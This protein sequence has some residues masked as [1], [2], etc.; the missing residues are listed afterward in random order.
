ML[1]PRKRITKREIKEDPLVTYYFKVRKFFQTYSKQVN[2]GLTVVAGLVIISVLMV[3]SK[4]NAEFAAAG[5]LGVA[6]NYYFSNMYERSIDELT[7]IIQTYSGTKAAG[8]ATFYLAN[9]YFVLHDFENAKKYYEIYR[10]K[11]NDKSSFTSSSLAGIAA[12]LESQEKFLE[13]AQYYEQ[14]AKT[15]DVSYQAPFYLKDACRCFALGGNVEKG[16]EICLL[17]IDKYPESNLVSDAKIY[18]EFL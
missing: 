1:K 5:K 15:N 3:R 4:R 6:V 8:N 16:R 17:I 12:C 18:L 13:A 2:I 10:K 7:P 11:Y 9:V 14:A